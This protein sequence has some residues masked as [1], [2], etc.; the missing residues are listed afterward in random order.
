[1]IDYIRKDRAIRLA[2]STDGGHRGKDWLVAQLE[3]IH[4]ADVR[5]NKR[6]EWLRFMG[7]ECYQCPECN[8][9]M[10]YDIPRNYCPNCGA[11][12][13]GGDTDG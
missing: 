8:Y 1:M 12:F 11:D 4:P 2:E 13:K 10:Q 9:G 7:G 5:L 3:M 6:R